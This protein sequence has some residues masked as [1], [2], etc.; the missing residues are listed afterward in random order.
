MRNDDSQRR[1]RHLRRWAVMDHALSCEI[2]KEDQEP[3][4]SQLRI[5]L[6][7]FD[8]NSLSLYLSVYFSLTAYLAQLLELLRV[9]VLEL[10]A[11]VVAEEGVECAVGVI[12]ECQEGPPHSL[13]HTT[14]AHHSTSHH[15][16]SHHTTS[17]RVTPHH[18]IA[19]KKR[20]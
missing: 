10:E 16:T 17:H 18:I 5:P 13:A 19:F 1:E 12:H 4:N 20:G 8:F 6:S 3:M 14:T 2:G 9:E 11:V 15:I 7:L